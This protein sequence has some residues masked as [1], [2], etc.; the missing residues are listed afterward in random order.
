MCFSRL[1]CRA[2]FGHSVSNL[3]SVIMEI[4]QKIWFFTSRLLRSLKVVGS[5]TDRSATYDFLLG[6]R[7]NYSPISYRFRDKWRYLQNYPKH[8]KPPLKGLPWNFVTAV[9]L[10]NRMMTL[11][12]Y[13]KRLTIF[14]LRA[15]EA[16]AQC[17]AIAFVCLCVFVCGSVTTITRTCMQRSSSNLVCM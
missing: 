9:G 10:K 12:E 1:Y 16:A 2:K 3:T 11:P 17:I 14:T 4:C 6:F 15:S 7:G 13:Q 5:N 8:L